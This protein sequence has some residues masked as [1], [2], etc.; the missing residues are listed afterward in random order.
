MSFTNKHYEFLIHSDDGRGPPRPKK[1]I[2]FLTLLW[3][4]QEKENWDRGKFQAE[5]II[6]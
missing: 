5:S 6:Y 2:V 1:W 3:S 4:G